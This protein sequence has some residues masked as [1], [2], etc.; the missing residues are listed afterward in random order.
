MDLKYIENVDPE[1][2]GAINMES[3]RQKNTLEL[4]ASENIV[5]RAVM[6]VQGSVFTNKYAEGYPDKRYYGG[7]EFVDVAEKLAVDRAKKLFNAPYANVQ[8]HS[9]SQAN[10]AAYLALL[11][12]REPIGIAVSE[13]APLGIRAETHLVLH[14]AGAGEGH[15]DEA[16]LL[17]SRLAEQVPEERQE[18]F[19][20]NN[21][22][23]RAAREEDRRRQA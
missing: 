2:A 15:L 11:G 3:H 9:G 22:T 19:W 5:S 21:P 1:I 10:A 17:L 6:A 23:A 13:Q 8:P 4:I 7:C 12:E 16:L 14:R 18:A 20:S